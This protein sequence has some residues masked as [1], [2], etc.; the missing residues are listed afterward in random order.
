M[1][2]KLCL[3]P[4]SLVVNLLHSKETC[5]NMGRSNLVKV[6]KKDVVVCTVFK[7]VTEIVELFKLKMFQTNCLTQKEQKW[8]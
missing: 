4:L 1:V 6:F 3:S 8:S 7:G 2:T 5:Y